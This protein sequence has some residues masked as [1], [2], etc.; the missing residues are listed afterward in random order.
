MASYAPLF[1]REGHTQWPVQLIWFDG[2]KSWVTPNYYVQQMFSTNRPD[3]ELP[4]EVTGSKKVFACAGTCGGETIVKIVNTDESPCT[5]KLN[6]K[7]SAKVTTLA[8][9]MEDINWSE[10][11]MV[12]PVSSE[13]TLDGPFGVPALSVTVL[14]VSTP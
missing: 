10:R 12:R 3:V 5:V 1:A 14:R 4:V 9:G 6:L 7:G 13:R 8:G 11:E 2:R